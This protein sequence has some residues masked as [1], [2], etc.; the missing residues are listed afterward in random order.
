[1]TYVWRYKGKDMGTT[2]VAANALDMDP[3]VDTN[4]VTESILR[5]CAD[6]K[7]LDSIPQSCTLKGARIWQRR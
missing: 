2:H 1:M 5:G 7:E 6:Q 3:S 4:E